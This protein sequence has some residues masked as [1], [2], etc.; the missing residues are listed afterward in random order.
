MFTLP[1]LISFISYYLFIINKWK[2]NIALVASGIF[3]G[4]SFFI[5]YK[6]GVIL[7][8]YGIFAMYS[9]ARETNKKSE[10]VK[11]LKDMIVIGTGF[12]MV[13]AGVTSYL[14]CNNALNDF[15]TLWFFI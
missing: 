7:I 4:I 15:I 14:Y 1:I 12:L 6:A 2:T 13:V 3:A 10:F 8:V 11:Q 9:I 5:N